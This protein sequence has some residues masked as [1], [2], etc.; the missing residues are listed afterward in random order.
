MQGLHCIKLCSTFF[1][2]WK[3]CAARAIIAAEWKELLFHAEWAGNGRTYV[4]VT[5][6]KSTLV[7]TL[8][9]ERKKGKLKEGKREP[10]GAPFFFFG[11][12]QVA[13]I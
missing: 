7:L 9:E 5:A 8:R 10:D 11:L 6:C 1:S 13:E 12:D 4:R 2:W 3:K